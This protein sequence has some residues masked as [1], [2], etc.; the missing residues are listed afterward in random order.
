M[1]FDIQAVGM[2]EL[3]ARIEAMK[4]RAADPRPGLLR[5]GMVVL[6]AAKD[7]IK[8]GAGDEGPWPPNI[9]GTPLLFKSGRL[10]NSLTI[11]GPE[12]F[13]QL[14]SSSIEVGT[15]VKNYPRWLQEGTGI[16]GPTG[17]RIFPKN[18][19]ALAFNGP[20]GRIVVRSIKGTPKRR[21]LYVDS[22]IAERVR[23]VFSEYILKG[24]PTTNDAGG[25]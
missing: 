24:L 18:K 13:M 22:A 25:A 12:N 5:A 10:I 15:S 17:Q 9:S 6:R 11:G 16:Y 20:G 2:A 7:H 4:A 14:D 21:F 8:S 19:K 23:S 3:R 1:H